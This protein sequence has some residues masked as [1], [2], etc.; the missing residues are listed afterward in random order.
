MRTPP[1]RHGLLALLMSALCVSS[2]YPQDLAGTR[3]QP[4]DSTKRRGAYFTGVYPDLFAEI[5][6]ASQAVVRARVD[7]AFHQ[8][9]H[10]TDTTER[11]Y[12]P[13][14]SDMAYVEDIAN[15]DVRTEG[16]SYGMMIAV[17]MDKKEEFDRLWRWAK[18]HM[19]FTSGP[20]EGY[21]AWHC[22]TDGTALDSTAASDGEEWF[23]MSLFFASARWGDGPGMYAYRVEAQRILATMLHKE[24]EP[25]HGNVTNMFNTKKK[26][27]AFVPD[28]KANHF[29][30]PSYQVPHFYELWARW[31]DTDNRFWCDAASASRRLLQRA[32]NP[33]TGLSP[34]YAGFDG[35][36]FSLRGGGHED[37]RFDA[38]R[39]AM[40]VAVDWIWFAQDGWAVTQSNRLLDFFHSQGVG[41]HGNQY[42]LDGR[43]LGNDHSAG[44]VAMNAVAGLASTNDNRQNFVEELWNTPVPSGQ[45]RYYDGMLYM[46]AMLQVSGNFRIYDPTGK[47]VPA[48]P[49]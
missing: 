29:T 38:W 40:N 1:G 42:T 43:K 7:S 2:A 11:V 35:K 31:A 37:F 44:L 21:F 17:Q 25:G 12:Y 5:A 36:P 32:A 6:G 3:Q 16:M 23:I 33:K 30:D 8:L 45:Y 13:V 39:V 34:D 47:A 27:V 19:Q 49:K 15:K 22:K 18:T 9:F 4:S 46:L 48:C 28:I 24:T 41:N 14:G 20:H 26:L 10:G